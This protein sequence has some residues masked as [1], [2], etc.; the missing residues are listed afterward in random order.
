[1]KK[2]ISLSAHLGLSR[3]RLEDV[4]VFDSILGIDTK[5]YIDPKLL[6]DSDIP[7]FSKARPELLLYFEKIIKIHNQSHI[8][9]RL[10]DEAKKLLAV[11]EPRGLSIGY[12]NK[13]DRGTAI[14]ESLANKLL[15]S[16]SEILAV[17]INDREVME[18][19]SLFVKGFACDR[20]SDLTVSILYDN[21]CLYTQ[22]IAKEL[23]VKTDIFTIN[24]K[25]FSLPKH[26]FSNKQII[27][28]PSNLLRSL[29]VATSWDEISEAAA[30]NE[31]LRREYTEIVLPTV[32]G[33]L[34]DLS[35]KSKEEIENF[36]KNMVQ[37][38]EVYK[39]ITVEPYNLYA[40]PNGYYSIQPFI[41]QESP[42]IKASQ[43]P[44]ND[45]G[46]KESVFEL[47][48]QFKRAIEDNGGNRLLYRKSDTGKLQKERP[49]NEDVAQII[50]YL[51]ADVFCQ[52][53]NILLTRESDAGKG[54]V[55]FSLGTGYK[56]K[57]LVEIKKSTNNNLVDGFNK[58]TPSYHKSENALYSFYVVIIVKEDKDIKRKRITQ[59]EQVINIYDENR[60][61]GIN[62]P[63]LFVIDGLI[64]PSPSKL[65]S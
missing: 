64:Y 44:K 17:G 53:S 8:S 4:G 45:Q 49:H 18:L 31:T 2:T 24:G 41:D 35:Q 32:K 47:I 54:R 36:K 23:G 63:E 29:P 21:F 61:N 56:Q 38:I 9:S 5:L 14:P 16:L 58:Q 48:T 22:R 37:L 62:T 39:K 40:D 12:G 26:P 57:I 25:K 46:V 19:L 30:Q 34:T 51:I 65:K 33:T 11:D 42:K 10:R 55:D 27:F 3:E 15:L 7:E 43:Q 52:Q 28:I 13:T 50:F 1:M 59:L 60:K 20:L 6:V